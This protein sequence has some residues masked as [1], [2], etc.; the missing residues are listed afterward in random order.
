MRVD[1]PYSIAQRAGDEGIAVGI[2][3]DPISNVKVGIMVGGEAGEED[4]AAGAEV[5][6]GGGIRGRG[7]GRGS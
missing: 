7:R 1:L 6:G 3:G 5:L 2:H 4:A